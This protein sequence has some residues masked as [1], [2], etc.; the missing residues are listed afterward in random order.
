MKRRVFSVAV[1]FLVLITVVS[2]LLIKKINDYSDEKMYRKY[3][4]EFSQIKINSQY[5]SAGDDYRAE[6]LEDS[7]SKYEKYLN[8]NI[9][10][11]NST[12]IK[13]LVIIEAFICLLFLCFVLM[14]IYQTILKPFDKM[15]KFADQ[16]AKGNFDVPLKYERGNYF[17]AFTWAFDNMRKEVIKARSSEKEAILKNKTVIA[18]ISHDIKT[19]IASIRA[20]SEGLAANLDKD[21]HK[22]EKYISVI[23]RKCDEVTNLANDLLLHSVSD[24]EKLK[25]EIKPENISQLLTDTL[26]NYKEM[27]RINLKSDMPETTVMLDR[28]RFEQVIENIIGNSLKYAGTEI[29]VSC[30]VLDEDYLI[31]IR[32]YGKGIP[33]EDMPFIFGKFFRG[34]NAGEKQGS[35]LGLFITKYIMEKHNGSIKLFNHDD[36]LEAI[37]RFPVCSEK[38]VKE[39]AL[40]AL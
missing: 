29:D 24:L 7:I 34:K 23:I 6:D 18:T 9:K 15:K 8:K 4:V 19:P 1:V 10:N 22:R 27:C 17:G 12:A 3:L 35:G 32:D 2:V 30:K 36:G 39:S 25:I 5:L 38:C 31:T 13:R 40:S 33:D 21:V 26:A 20:Y 14:Y 28:Q 37:L 11:Q 16:I